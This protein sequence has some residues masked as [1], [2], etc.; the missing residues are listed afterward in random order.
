MRF[1]SMSCGL[2]YVKTSIVA[3]RHVGHCTSKFCKVSEPAVSDQRQLSDK[4]M[5]YIYIYIYT[6]DERIIKEGL[7]RAVQ[8]TFFV[9]FCHVVHSA[10]SYSHYIKYI[11]ELL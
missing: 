7:Y 11:H 10:S 6:R 8:Q 3:N 9:H 5:S 4:I 2:Y 1:S